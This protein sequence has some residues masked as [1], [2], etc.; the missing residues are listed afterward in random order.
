MSGSSWVIKSSWLSR[1]LRSFLYSYFVCSCYLYLISSASLR[2][3]HILSFIV[4]IFAWNVPLVSL[5]FLTG[6]LVFPI[7]LFPSIFCI[8]HLG[9]LSCLSL[10]F[11]GTLISNGYIFPFLLCI[12]LLFF[13]QLFVR[14][15]QTTI[16]PSCISFSQNGFG[17]HLLYDVTNLHP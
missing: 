15:P 11:F 2:W 3:I 16:L 5:I 17:H 4:P 9:R 13:S 1:S 14:P 10:L 7:L 6:S 12:L 8:V